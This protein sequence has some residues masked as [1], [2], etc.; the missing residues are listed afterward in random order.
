MK[1][2]GKLTAFQHILGAIQQQDIDCHQYIKIPMELIGKALLRAW[3]TT[4]D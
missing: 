1:Q 4:T 3:Y 2:Y